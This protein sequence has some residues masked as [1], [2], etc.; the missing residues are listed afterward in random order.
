MG[1]RGGINTYAYVG[2][3]P[4]SYFDPNGLAPY[5]GQSP[6]SNIPGGPWSPAG[7]GQRPG[8]F[9]LARSNLAEETFAGT[10]PMGKAVGPAEQTTAIG[11][12]RAP[13]LLG[14]AMTTMAT[15]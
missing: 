5:G 12:R 9:F 4:L 2:G 10:F 13:T 3:N 6:P 14:F 15:R 1:L 7:S 11:R 8:T